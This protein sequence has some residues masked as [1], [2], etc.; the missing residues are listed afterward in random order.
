[1]TNL[2]PAFSIKKGDKVLDYRVGGN[3]NVDQIK[4]FFE[5]RGYAIDSILPPGRH[6]ICFGKK[7]GDDVVDMVTSPHGIW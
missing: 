7:D 5:K 6:I 3:V 2:L 1:M 4:T